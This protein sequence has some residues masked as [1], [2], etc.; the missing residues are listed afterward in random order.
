MKA[1]NKLQSVNINELNDTEELMYLNE[2]A[3]HY[4]LLGDSITADSLYK[5]IDSE[6][7]S[8]PNYHFYSVPLRKNSREE[9][10]AEYFPDK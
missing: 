8:N 3:M 9:I 1:I 2:L 7:K 5:V 10:L 6:F 4:T